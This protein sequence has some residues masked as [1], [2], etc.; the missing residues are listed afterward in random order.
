[1]EWERYEL[2][3]DDAEFK[4]EFYS[5]GP[6]G[7]IRKVVEF[8]QLQRMSDNFYN[9]YFGDFVES[10]GKVDALAV[11]NNKDRSKILL[12]IAAIVHDF[13]QYRP[14]AIILAVGSTNA[15]TRLYQMSISFFWK[16]IG[17]LYVVYGKLNNE[18]VYFEKNVNYDG[19][20]MFKKD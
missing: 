2:A 20:L 14:K 13:M 4:Y 11:S 15:R 9:L 19:F 5:E 3:K 6:K 18:W 10:T 17:A 1:M 8:Q 16:E 7:R 12:T